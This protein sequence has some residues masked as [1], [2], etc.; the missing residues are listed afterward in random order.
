MAALATLLAV[1]CAP[2]PA[3][4]GPYPRIVL[5]SLDTLRAHHLGAYGYPRDT[6]PFLDELAAGGVL[7][8][9]AYSAISVTSPSHASL[10]TSLYPLQHGVL[11]NG[12]KLDESFVTLAEL[13]RER[14]FATA[15]FVSTDTHFEVTNLDQGFAVFDEPRL[16]GGEVYR[17]ATG[18]VDAA[19]RW[20]EGDAGDRPFFLFV[21]LFDAHL[22]HRPPPEHSAAVAPGSPG[23]ER[24][25]A[26]Y[27][28][29]TQHVDPGAFR[30]GR[31]GI[32]KVHTD[33]GGEI[34]YVDAEL[35]RLYDAVAA[36]GLAQ[37]TLWV[38]TADH[39]E[40]L[41]NHGYR[42]HGRHVYDE[43]VRVPLLF[44]AEEPSLPARRVSDL[45]EQ[46]D[47]LPTLAAL[48]GIDASVLAS[49]GPL[50][51]R[52]LLP[53]LEGRD[54]GDAARAAF[55]QRRSYTNADRS[56]KMAAADFE[57]GSK[58]GWIG[59]RWKYIHRTIGADE[60]YD[61]ASDPYETRNLLQSNADEAARLKRALLDR[62]RAL[63]DGAPPTAEPVDEDTLKKLEALGYVP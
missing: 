47:V 59:P 23:E 6:S 26:R 30:R 61:L 40:G 41:G 44:Y 9:R 60:L 13:L 29:E 42:H 20:L 12:E 7:F 34:R 56:F 22:P 50:Q 45:V 51:G 19:L 27:L 37:G 18:T 38:V 43:Q 21:H 10:F 52:S 53:L 36:L 62:V 3:P 24:D 54:S 49:L 5:V 2:Q 46:I 39:G 48:A 11:R 25:L 8:E 15:G 16:P 58:Y 28:V 32:V 63:G 35:R 1:A 17:R 4:P 14:G 57:L 55:V 33:Y 31:A